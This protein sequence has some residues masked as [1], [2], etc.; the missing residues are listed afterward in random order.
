[1][2]K[3]TSPSV[4][5]FWERKNTRSPLPQHKSRTRFPRFALLECGNCEEEEEEGK[6]SEK[7]NKGFEKRDSKA[8]EKAK[9][10]NP[11]APR[12]AHPFPGAML[13][14]AQHVI[15]LPNSFRYHS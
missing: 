15:E 6:D 1:M 4:P 9:K 12:D 10:R 5:T 11:P 2:D 7:G 14:Q 3:R 13:S 8:R